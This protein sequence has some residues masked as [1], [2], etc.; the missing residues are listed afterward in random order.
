MAENMQNI[1]NYLKELNVALSFT[2]V[3]PSTNKTI[4]LKQLN[5]DQLK[6]LLETIAD[7]ATITNKFN[8]TFFDILKENTLTQ[9]INIDDITIYDAQYLAL[10]MRIN[11]LS[12]KLTIYFTEEEIES[13]Q[14]PG[15][16]HEINLKEIVAN[17]KL[18]VIPD[19]V[20]I[21]G[22]IKVTCQVPSIKDENIFTK[23]FAENLEVLSK[24]DLDNI[25]GEIFIYEI[26]KSIKDVN[27]NEIETDYT[28]LTLINKASIVK[29]LPTTLT[30][31]IVSFIEKYKQALYDLYLVNIEVQ[32]QNNTF[33]LQKELQFSHTLFN[34]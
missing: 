14:L 22:S 6:R 10:Q 28:N 18:N 13:Y 26:V 16:S 11:S 32:T 25:I 23:Y 21:E 29:E 12:E 1:L 4:T 27:I 33:L 9:D 8:Y 31:K 7:S 3:I 5:T 15:T 34:Y 2:T 20:I 17:K 30:S 24:K 19:E